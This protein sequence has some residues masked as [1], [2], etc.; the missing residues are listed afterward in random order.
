MVERRA[1]RGIAR[2]WTVGLCLCG[3]GLL[4]AMLVPAQAEAADPTGVY[5][6]AVNTGWVS[7]LA[8]SDTLVEAAVHADTATASATD[9][10]DKAKSSSDVRRA[11][12]RSLFNV[13]VGGETAGRQFDYHDGISNDLRSYNVAP[14][15]MV[16]AAAEV[17]PFADASNV[18]RDVG[19]TGS[20]AH[21]LFLKSAVSGGNDLTTS[22]ST[23]SLGLR[24]RI[25]P[26]G[27]D[28]S[29]IG[30]SYQYVGQAVAFDSAGESVE[31]QLPSVDYRA[32]R[33]GVDVRVP[34]GKLAAVAGLGFRAVLSAGEVEA[35]F[36]SPSVEGIDGELG[37]S[38]AVAP[39]WEARAVLDYER[40]FYSFQPVPGDEYVAGGALDQFFGGRL[41]IAY[42]F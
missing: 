7:G 41:V 26:W 14:A 33:I 37:A 13:E 23:Y 4:V 29:L 8:S 24:L 36:H 3:S 5:T 2:V 28:G 9:A 34:F 1:R 17:F 30:V 21:S 12:N 11:F 19:L 18:L 42:V 20:Y 15:A 27:D 35:R 16:S 25:H 40:Y 38:L 6:G 31:E 39:G 32:N 10:P 22:Y